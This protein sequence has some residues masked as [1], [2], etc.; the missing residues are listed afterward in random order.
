MTN[1]QGICSLNISAVNK[2]KHKR[3]SNMKEVE[4]DVLEI[5]F[6]DI[7]EKSKGEYLDVYRGIQLEI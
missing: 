6:G 2:E 3:N 1:T 4:R 5:D 7:P